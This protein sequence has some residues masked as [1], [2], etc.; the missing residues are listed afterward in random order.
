MFL[1]LVYQYR[2]RYHYKNW[3]FNLKL[4][5]VACY[6]RY[7]WQ[8]FKFKQQIHKCINNKIINLIKNILYI[9]YI[10]A[11]ICTIVIKRQFVTF[12]ISDLENSIEILSFMFVVLFNCDV[13]VHVKTKMFW[14]GFYNY[15]LFHILLAFLISVLMLKTIWKTGMT[16]RE[17]NIKMDIVTKI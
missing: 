17:K 8:W 4:F 11:C 13:L 14:H 1:Y 7:V 5:K 2:Q 16:E 15:I 3:K 12:G 9:S 6:A 10:W